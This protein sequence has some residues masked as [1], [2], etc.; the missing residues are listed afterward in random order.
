MTRTEIQ[1]IALLRRRAAV[2]KGREYADAVKRGDTRDQHKLHR[3]WVKLKAWAME[4]E[5][6]L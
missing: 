6:K 4:A 3:E 1:T 5:M 2:L